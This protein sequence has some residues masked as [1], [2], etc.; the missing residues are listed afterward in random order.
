MLLYCFELTAYQEEVAV[1]RMKLNYDE[2][3]SYPHSVVQLWE[4]ILN[5]NWPSDY[6]ALAK[7]VEKGV[8]K[9]RRGEAWRLLVK[10]RD[11]IET[12]QPSWCR[13]VIHDDY[14]LCRETIDY[15]R[16]PL[17]DVRY[18]ELLHQLTSH[19]HAIIIDLSRTFPT[20]KFFEASL[21]PGQLALYNLLKAYSLLDTEVGYCQGLSFIAG[22]LLLHLDEN[23]AYCMLRYLMLQLGL[24]RQYLPDMAALQIQLYQMARLLRDLHRDLYQH[25]EEHEVSPTLYAAPWFLTLF[26]SQF[27]LGFVVRVFGTIIFL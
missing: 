11:S 21:G 20:L 8:P 16:F 26:A 3:V 6:L 22:V 4:K 15:D 2:I 7:A 19:Q 5:G 10:T 13:T 24:R 18:E 27:P 14:S 9:Q 1:K 17:L 23:E 25:L 12:V